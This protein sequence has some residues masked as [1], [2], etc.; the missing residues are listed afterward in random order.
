MN[1]ARG[2][3]QFNTTVGGVTTTAY[4]LQSTVPGG[5]GGYCLLRSDGGAYAYD[6]SGEF[7]TTFANGHNL[8]AMLSPAVFTTPTL[9]T[10]ATPTPA[11]AIVGVTGNTLSLH[12]TGVPPGTLLEVFVTAFEGAETRRTNFLV[13]V[14]A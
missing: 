8:V 12:V 4:V 3:G 14:M 11:G 2:V 6:G 13:N 1:R 7:S 5:V 10:R 9:L